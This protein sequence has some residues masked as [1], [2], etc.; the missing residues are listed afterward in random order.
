M[1]WPGGGGAP[2][3]CLGEF[4]ARQRRGNWEHLLARPRTGAMDQQ[5][6]TFPGARIDGSSAPSIIG[7]AHQKPWVALLF[8]QGWLGLLAF[9]LVRGYALTQI[10]RHFLRWA[11]RSLVGTGW[12]VALWARSPADLLFFLTLLVGRRM[13]NPDAMAGK[14]VRRSSRGRRAP[15]GNPE[16]PLTGK[17]SRRVPANCSFV[18]RSGHRRGRTDH[19]GT[20][21]HVSPGIPIQRQGGD[22]SGSRICPPSA[23]PVLVWSTGSPG[24][25]QALV[26]SAVPAHHVVHAVATAGLIVMAAQRVGP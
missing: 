5:W 18:A 21:R 11:I 23:V 9:A 19:A 20:G 16:P 24:S 1:S 8:E 14:R 17:P 12:T 3:P 26:Q 2:S 15:V 22:L 4:F 10:T 13:G 7:V 6:S 25:S